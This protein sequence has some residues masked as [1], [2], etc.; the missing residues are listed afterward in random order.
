[1]NIRSSVTSKNNREFSGGKTWEFCNRTT[2]VERHFY[3]LIIYDDSFHFFANNNFS[4]S[5]IERKTSRC[6][7]FSLLFGPKIK[8]FHSRNIRESYFSKWIIHFVRKHLCCYQILLFFF[9]EFISLYSLCDFPHK[10]W[11]CSVKICLYFP[12]VDFHFFVNNI[13]RVFHFGIPFFLL[14]FPT[15]FDDF[16][17]SRT[18]VKPVKIRHLEEK[19]R[20][21]AFNVTAIWNGNKVVNI[22]L[23]NQ[24]E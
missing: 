22:I 12:L 6:V 11:N 13:F 17:L 2:L 8:F 9:V 4:I 1:M 7:W 23:C 14:V 19:S 24:I 10:N 15:F 16:P 21:T 18:Y 3:S 20:K 5:F